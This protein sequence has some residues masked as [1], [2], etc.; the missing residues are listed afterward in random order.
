MRIKFLEDKVAYISGAISNRDIKEVVM[1]FIIVE[2]LL[3]RHGVREVL[4]PLSNGLPITASWEDHMKEDIR[5]L[6]K[7]DYVFMLD[8]WETSRGAK[9]EHRLAKELGIQIIYLTNKDKQ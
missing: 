8:G 2:N 4:N 6:T 7:A 5:L 9:I 1:D 3:K